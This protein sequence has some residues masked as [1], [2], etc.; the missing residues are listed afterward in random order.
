MPAKKVNKTAPPAG[1]YRISAVS[2]MTGIPAPTIRIWE[3]RY[4]AVSPQRSSGNGRLYTRQ[5]VDRLQLLKAVVDAGFQIG[6]I[7]ALAEPQLRERLQ[8][9][10]QRAAAPGKPGR[11]AVTV[12][13]EPLAARLDAAW[14][15]AGELQITAVLADLDAPA[16]AAASAEILIVDA[17]TL[18]LA[19]L[20]ALRRLR[21]SLQPRLT[22]VVYGYGTRRSLRQ[23]DDEGVLAVSAPSDPVHLARICHL[24]LAADPAP[25]L[26]AIERLLREPAAARRYDPAFLGRLGDLP[27][28]VQCECPNHLAELLTRLG[29]FEQYSLDCESRNEDDAALH[30]RLHAAA[31][32][33]RELLE[34]VLLQV[35]EHE[36]IASV[37]A[38][39]APAAA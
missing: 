12:C 15:P 38:P 25:D 36:G 29:A 17:A 37:E 3:F 4:G 32:R 1:Q 10:P 21:A 28:Q 16:V 5:D 14:Q 30:G 31:S 24:G 35:L 39:S 11:H 27:T 22:V 6:T 9:H 2:I 8:A 26:S 13:G 18:S 33:C 19:T 7:A 23:L 20:Q 34:H